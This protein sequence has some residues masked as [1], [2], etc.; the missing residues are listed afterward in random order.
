MMLP[1]TTSTVGKW[2]V[3]HMPRTEEQCKDAAQRMNNGATIKDLPAYDKQDMS[4]IVARA[5]W[6]DTYS[7]QDAEDGYIPSEAYE[8]EVIEG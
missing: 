8:V 2:Y 3:G 6:G 4:R 5:P 1:P 7:A